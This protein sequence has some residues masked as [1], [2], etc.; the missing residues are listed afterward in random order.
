VEA[1]SGN[2]KSTLFLSYPGSITQLIIGS[3]PT[4]PEEKRQNCVGS[5]TPKHT[6]P[7]TIKDKG[8]AVRLKST[9]CRT[10]SRHNHCINLQ[11]YIKAMRACTNG[12]IGIQSMR[13]F[14]VHWQCA[15]CASTAS[16]QT[17]QSRNLWPCLTLF[18]G[19][20]SDSQ[21][22]VLLTL[23]LDHTL[24]LLHCRAVFLKDLEWTT[25]QGSL[26][27]DCFHT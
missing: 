9:A 12:Y 4:Q 5:K 23:C 19:W 15:Q 1:D 24:R 8:P 20:I 21:E 11:K 2:K 16:L 7:A 14:S 22:H 17:G 25:P 3:G 6:L 10:A 18:G 27:Q 26:L 13:V